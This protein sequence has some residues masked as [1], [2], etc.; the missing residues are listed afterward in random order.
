M[1]HDYNLIL[2]DQT[3]G[4]QEVHQL[5]KPERLTHVTRS[6]WER[7]RSVPE[8]D[9]R[10]AVRKYLT[11]DELNALVARREL[12]VKHFESLI[13]TRGEGAVVQ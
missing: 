11:A 7:L 9:L 6:T 12:V 3:R 4:F 2:I 13:E 5:L 1:T 10:S 8:E